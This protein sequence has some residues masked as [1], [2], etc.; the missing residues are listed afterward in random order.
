[1]IGLR[2]GCA[3]RPELRVVIPAGSV[4][5]RDNGRHPGGR[6][7]ALNQATADTLLRYVRL[8]EFLE[9]A[10]AAA[11]VHDSTVRYWKRYA[12]EELERGEPGPFA[13]FFTAL[14]EAAALAQID[15]LREIRSGGKNWQAAAWFKERT[16]S[17]WRRRLAIAELDED[18]DADAGGLE[19]RVRVVSSRPARPEQD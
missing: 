18:E 2:V 11:G 13:Q 10:A 3:A 4:R 6:P 19:V 9:I 14:K 16:S 15:A 8:G 5:P 1:M 17:R 12:A 7:P